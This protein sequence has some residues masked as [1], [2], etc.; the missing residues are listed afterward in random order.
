MTKW[1]SAYNGW[2]T[3]FQTYA[4][5]YPSLK[6]YCVSKHVGLHEMMGCMTFIFSLCW[7]S[8]AVLAFWLRMKR[9]IAS[10]FALNLCACF[11]VSDRIG[12][13]RTRI[14]FHL[15]CNH[16]NFQDWGIFYLF[17]RPSLFKKV[18]PTN[19]N[20]MWGNALLLELWRGKAINLK[21]L[22]QT[23]PSSL[24]RTLN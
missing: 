6:P 8:A 1:S 5:A 16:S 19:S 3:R 7:H 4:R 21:S 17:R 22:G 20:L 24:D 9:G 11:Y 18:V 12:S 2:D 10:L 23:I 14:D 15:W 13:L